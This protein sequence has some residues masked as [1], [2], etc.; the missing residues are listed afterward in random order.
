[1]LDERGNLLE[2]SRARRR[3]EIPLIMSLSFSHAVSIIWRYPTPPATSSV[4]GSIVSSTPASP[5]PPSTLARRPSEET[6][7]PRRSEE[8][9]VVFDASEGA[10]IST[11]ESGGVGGRSEEA[12]A[13]PGTPGRTGRTGR[14]PGDYWVSGPD[15]G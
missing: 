9:E 2:P 8:G 15:R 5:A 4:I 7:R 6:V 11:A 13:I 10:G 14:M 12:E 3:R 1:V